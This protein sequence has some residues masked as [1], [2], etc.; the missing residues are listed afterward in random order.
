M[1][2]LR[3]AIVLPVLFLTVALLGGVRLA[4]DARLVPPTLAALLLGTLLVGAFLRARVLAP[5]ALMHV[6]R[7]WLENTSGAVVILTLFAASAQMFNLLTPEQGLLHVIFIVF[8]GVQL[9]TTIAAIGERA[10]MLRSVAVLFGA[11]FALRFVFLENLYAPGG[12]LVA[13]LVTAAAEGVTLGALGYTSHA[14]ATGYVGFAT[15]TLYLIGLVLVGQ[16]QPVAAQHATAIS[17][18]GEDAPRARQ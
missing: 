13:R 4:A 1:T 15:L 14:P 6:R 12:G 9:L 3:E 10:A 8:F 2:A 5:E 7:T 17:T 16:P 11:M 18:R